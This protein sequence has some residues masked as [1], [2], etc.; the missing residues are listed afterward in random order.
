V[1]IVLSF[2]FVGH[3]FNNP[4]RDGSVMPTKHSCK[5]ASSQQLSNGDER[6]D[7]IHDNRQNVLISLADATRTWTEDR[8]SVRAPLSFLPKQTAK[9]MYPH[10][11]ASIIS[12]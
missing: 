3:C 5:H 8:T 9:K 2:E 7:R 12:R 11:E 1:T 10:H 6:N 4:E